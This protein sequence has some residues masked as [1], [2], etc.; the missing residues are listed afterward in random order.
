MLP[1]DKQGA[2]AGRQRTAHGLADSTAPHSFA[3]TLP[4]AVGNTWPG[5]F[6]SS[7]L[8][9]HHFPW[10]PATLHAMPSTNPAPFAQAH[11]QHSQESSRPGVLVSWCPD[12][13]VPAD[14][15]SGPW[16]DS[17]ASCPWPDSDEQ[18]QKRSRSRPARKQRQR[19]QCSIGRGRGR[20]RSRQSSVNLSFAA[21]S[22]EA[23]QREVALTA[24]AKRAPDHYQ[25]RG[26][27]RNAVEAALAVRSVALQVCHAG[28]IRGC[29][30]QALNTSCAHGC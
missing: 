9:G 17:E 7:A 8:L 23:V 2:Q 22:S 6:N 1:S 27:D 20:G 29:A 30:R 5:G 26:C 24:A 11:H 3:M 19:K 12:M 28:I 10:P 15:D 4:P 16:P 21:G 18:D 25:Q 14:Q 13:M